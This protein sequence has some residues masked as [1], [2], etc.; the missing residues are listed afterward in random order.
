MSTRE[1]TLV[2]HFDA[3]RELVFQAW[4]D[5]A[6]LTQWSGPDGFTCPPDS[7]VVEPHAGGRYDAVMV[8]D[9]DGASY[10]TRGV[11]REVDEPERLVFTWGDPTGDGS[12]ERESVITVTFEE[13]ASDKTTMTFHL[14][15][16]G[17]LSAEDG[18]REGWSQTL[19]RLVA[20]F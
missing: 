17:S 16:P 1:I 2:R 19:D 18:A 13:T 3:P 6:Q 9:T 7:F 5:P 15:A 10:P 14:L 8:S 11:F 20:L 12:P 4:L